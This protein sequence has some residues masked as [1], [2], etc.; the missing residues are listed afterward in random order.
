MTIFNSVYKSFKEWWQPWANTIAYYPL[1]EDFNDHSSSWYNLTS[2]S[3]QL[4]TL[5]W[6]KCADLNSSYCSANFNLTSLPYTIS[7]YLKPKSTSNTIAIWFKDNGSRWGSWIYVKNNQ[8]YL[9]YWNSTDQDSGTS[10]T[11]NTNWNHIVVTFWTDGSKIYVNG[12]LYA[13]PKNSLTNV[14]NNWTP[15]YIWHDYAT[16]TYWNSYVW[17]VIL[18]N[19]VRTAQEISDYYDLT[20]WD[21]WIS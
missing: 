5:S 8:I 15:F 20:K 10:Y 4:T 2:N 16:T 6:V 19:K 11:I 21:Y 9:R 12:S 3:V 14:V 13:S 1:T 7:F 18:E 17:S